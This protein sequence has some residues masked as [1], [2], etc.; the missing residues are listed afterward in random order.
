MENIVRSVAGACGDL[1]MPEFAALDG[2]ATRDRDA[3]LPVGGCDCRAAA[4]AFR[5]GSHNRSKAS[6]IPGVAMFLSSVPSGVIP[7]TVIALCRAVEQGGFRSW[8][9]G[10]SLRDIL[11]GRAPKDWDLATSATPQQV[12]QLF[13]RVIPTGIDHGTVTVLWQGSSYELTTLRGEGGYADGRRPD[14]VYFIEDIE[15]D[16][17]RRDFTVNALAYDPLR[18]VLIDPFGGLADMQRR[19]IRTVGSAAQR[20]GEDG[21]RVLRAARFAA[22]LQFE[23][24]PETRAGISQSLDVFAKVSP[25]RVRDEWL[26]T[27]QAA[28]PSRGFT[29]M[30]ETGMMAVTNPELAEQFGCT[31]NRWHAYDVWTH[32]MKCMDACGGGPV[33]RLAGLLHDLGKPRT[34][35]L[36]DKTGDYTF[37]N[38]E[39]VGARMADLWLKRYRFSN[40]ERERVV[41]LVQH[42][43][44][45]YSDE[46]SDGAVRRFVRRVGLGHIDAL[47]DLARAD[48]I[49]KGKPVDEELAALDRLRERVARV[50]EQGAAFGIRELAIDGGDVMQR[51]GI[52]PGPV[53][54][55]ILADLLQRVLDEPELNTRDALLDLVDTSPLNPAK[56]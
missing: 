31:Q 43:L 20:F 44:V 30:L 33:H 27:L 1:S 17:A 29:V 54:G 49:G 42:H 37:Y 5:L 16:L 19:T 53:V 2:C 52:R 23:I 22:T 21:L 9:V 36:S 8:L 24:E 3:W 40:D 10:G 51:L 41:H 45:C 32:S 18:D 38:H 28:E 7:E 13:K 55:K 12:M 15:R 11:M 35:A 25:E 56:Q 6:P 46:W 39:S 50:Q 4:S 48:A 14:H 47:L 34:R 26:R